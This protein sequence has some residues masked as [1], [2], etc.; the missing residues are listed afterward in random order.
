M[1]QAYSPTLFAASALALGLVAALLVLWVA[2]SQPWLGVRLV[3]GPD[4]SA[5]VYSVHPDGPA[6]GRVLQGSR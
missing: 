5:I 4:G 6:E 1:K 3:A 2:L